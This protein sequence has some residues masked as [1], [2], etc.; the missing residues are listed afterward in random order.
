[1]IPES[2]HNWVGVWVGRLVQLPGSRHN[3][4]GVQAVEADVI[5]RSFPFHNHENYF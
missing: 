3:F 1:M 4:Q 2:K 5:F